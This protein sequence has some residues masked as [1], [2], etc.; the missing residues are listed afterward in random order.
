MEYPVRLIRDDND[1][2]LVDF[3]DFP[4]AHTFGDDEA[5]ALA[6]A[7]DALTTILHSFMRERR[8]IPLPSAEVTGYRVAVPAMVAAKV[9]LYRAMRTSRVN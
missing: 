7:V 1:T 9:Q 2:I 5:D 6:H 8:D 4:E 3:V